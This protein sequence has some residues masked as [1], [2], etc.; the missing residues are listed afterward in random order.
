M[1]TQFETLPPE[2]VLKICAHLSASDL[3]KIAIFSERLRKLFL[4]LIR[5]NYE[6]NRLRVCLFRVVSSLT[7]S[8]MFSI[9]N[10][11]IF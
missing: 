1:F 9:D 4:T 5:I 3:R 8:S 6:R 11:K 2:L 10:F 7:L